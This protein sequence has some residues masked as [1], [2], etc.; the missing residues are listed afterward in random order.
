M[1]GPLSVAC[2][3]AL[4]CCAQAFAPLSPARGLR[5]GARLQRAAGRPETFDSVEEHQAYLSSIDA[6]P[7]GFRI[8][9]C[10]FQF[11]P[12]EAPTMS[13]T[14]N[15]T[16]IAL[17]EPTEAFGAV[18]TANRFPGA[19]VK[20]VRRRLEEKAVQ[21]IV[22]NNK[23]SNVCPGGDG[24]DGEADSEA[25]CEATAK[26]L[27][28]AGKGLVLPS[29]TGVI[30]W[31]LPVSDIVGALPAAVA[32]LNSD[33]ALQGAKSIMTTDRYPK[34]RSRSLTLSGGARIVGIVKGAG[35]IEPNMATMLGFIFTDAE[36]PREE[37]RAALS[38]CV[39]DTFNCISVDSDE[40]TSDT[41]MLLS[42]GRKKCWTEGAEAREEFRSALREVC[43]GLA[44]DVVRNGEG[45][46]HVMRVAIRNAGEENKELAK[47]MGRAVVNSPLFKCAVA[48]NDPNVGRLIAA[49]GKFAGREG[50]T[51]DP[52]RVELRLG[53]ETIFREGRFELDGEKETRLSDVL[54][55]AEM[56]EEMAYPPHERVVDIA[57]DLG[58]GGGD[59]AGATLYGSDLTHAYV[60]INADYRS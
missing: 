19:P 18:T 57:I 47:R 44:Q 49:I 13:A 29:S 40:S 26:A 25:I 20:V 55:A 36:V 12:V 43:A 58:I 10:G 48:G 14:M 52:S 21:A 59:D 27:G 7:E 8:G 5:A 39:Q 33:G 24:V 50:L 32:A 28:I 16:I 30:G 41:V 54:K 4:W 2:L 51:L 34:L 42:S 22:V 1:V 38:D 15:V 17:D 6:L 23:I 46:Q 37:L 35:M 45:T 31:R 11:C 60:S 9:T 56:E 53:G 3:L